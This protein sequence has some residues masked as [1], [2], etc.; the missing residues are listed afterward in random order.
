MA[1]P[2]VAAVMAALEAAGGEGAPRFVGGCVR[3]PLLGG[4]VAA[5][6]IATVLTLP[7]LT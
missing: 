6:D 7:Q 2:P 3:D 5:I 4:A 1:E